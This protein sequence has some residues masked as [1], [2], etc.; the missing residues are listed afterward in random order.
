LTDVFLSNVNQSISQCI[1]QSVS[2][3][4]KQYLLLTCRHKDGDWDDSGQRAR[5][6]TN[7][8]VETQ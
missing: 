3:S 6:W 4:V 5:R 7:G 1:S 2:Q 8:R